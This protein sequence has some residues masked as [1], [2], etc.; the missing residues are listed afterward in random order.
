MIEQDK[1]KLL[2][3]FRGEAARIKKVK[4]K[5]KVKV[6]SKRKILNHLQFEVERL[7]QDACKKNREMPVNE[8]LLL[9]KEQVQNLEYRM[10][11][12]ETERVCESL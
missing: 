12:K 4:V 11:C 8:G 1:N 3:Y 6:E 9:S 2:I 7:K 10:L 5:V